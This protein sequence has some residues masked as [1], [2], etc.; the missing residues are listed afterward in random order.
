M[1]GICL[2]VILGVVAGAFGSLGSWPVS[3]AVSTAATYRLDMYCLQINNDAQMING[4][5]GG[6]VAATV[7]TDAA[8]NMP[9]KHIATVFVEPVRARIA[10]NQ[11]TQFLEDSL[12]GKGG[13]A[14][15]TIYYIDN[16]GKV[17]QQR[18]LTGLLL[19]EIAFPAFSGAR[20]PNALTMTMTM[21]AQSSKASD[22]LADALP[23]AK[24]DISPAARA[25]RW[26]GDWRLQVPGLPT[27][28]VTSIEAFTLRRKIQ[29]D[30]I[31][32]DIPKPMHWDIPNLVFYMT[33]QDS[34][35]WLAWH[36]DFVIQ[37]NNSDA[38]EKTFT[39]DLLTPDLKDTLLELQG[40][41]VGI[42][43]AKYEQPVGANAPAIGGFRVELYVET[44][45]LV[46]GSAAATSTP[47]SQP[48][49][50]PSR[51][52]ETLVKPTTIP[53]KES[54]GTRAPAQ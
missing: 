27:S 26:A 14:S 30:T 33:P 32:P 47:A 34:K 16:S 17:Q 49:I 3:A 5:E 36:D 19:S 40:S 37:S 12:E 1:R 46:P 31:R 50:D 2:F 52:T 35:A 22:P 9:K 8:G 15:G 6:S 4:I 7:A 39:L 10:V 13:Y 54:T 53:V 11:F 48:A 45:K 25:K 20:S 41:G 44:I 18:A 51:P 43:S 23:P 28:R 24:I 29:S 42:V 21:E 38:Q